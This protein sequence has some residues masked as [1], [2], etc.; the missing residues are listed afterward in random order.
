MKS[1]QAS[2]YRR[3]YLPLK[4]QRLICSKIGDYG[5]ETWPPYML[6]QNDLYRRTHFSTQGCEGE[7][8]LKI[9]EGDSPYEPPIKNDFYGQCLVSNSFMQTTFFN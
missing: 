4:K 5:E 9:G 8:Y 6:P 3:S 7:P 1:A 2:A